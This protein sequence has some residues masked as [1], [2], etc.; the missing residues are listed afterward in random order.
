MIRF[1]VLFIAALLLVGCGAPEKKKTKVDKKEL[2]GSYKDSIYSNEFFNFKMT[3][4]RPWKVDKHDFQSV[5]FGGKLFE[6]KYR[7]SH[8]REYPIDIT[9]E[10]EKANPFGSKSP[11]SKLKE[12]QEGYEMFYSPSELMVSDFKKVNLGGKDFAHAEFTCIADYDTSYIHEYYRYQDKYFLSIVCIYNT[13][14]DEQV[15][16]EMVNCMQKL[17]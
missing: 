2:F 14:Q 16:L 17:K 10:V 4:S 6:A 15:A 11:V 8:N 12:S 7:L 9:M 5:A 3:F 1:S 13:K